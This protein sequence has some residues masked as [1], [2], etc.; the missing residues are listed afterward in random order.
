MLAMP[1]SGQAAQ[2]GLIRCTK[3]ALQCGVRKAAN[4]PE[5]PNLLFLFIN[6]WA[7]LGLNQRPTG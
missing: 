3:F 7:V 5:T 2:R 6:F 4:L 1:Q